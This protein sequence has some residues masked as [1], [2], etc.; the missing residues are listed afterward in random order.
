MSLMP[1]GGNNSMSQVLIILD[2]V[3]YIGIQTPVQNGSIK[4]KNTLALI[5]E[6]NTKDKFPE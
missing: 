2:N 4:D 6:A 5:R 1:K 3:R